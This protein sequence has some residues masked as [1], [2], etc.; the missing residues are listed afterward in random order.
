M[1][2]YLTESSFIWELYMRHRGFS[3]EEG[4]GRAVGGGG[5]GGE[6]VEGEIRG[7]WVLD[8]KEM[9]KPQWLDS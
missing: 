9:Q 3:E 2:A 1:N 6:E 4:G 7:A 8:E 5:G